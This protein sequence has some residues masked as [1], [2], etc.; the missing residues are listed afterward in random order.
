MATVFGR[1]GAGGQDGE[2]VPGRREGGPPTACRTGVLF[3]QD[4]P[5]WVIPLRIDERV[6]LRA[7][8]RRALRLVFL[9]AAVQ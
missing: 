2:R 9:R 5:V 7:T 1:S 8:T 3:D 6:K 4:G